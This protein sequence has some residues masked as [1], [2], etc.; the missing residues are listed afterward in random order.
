MQGKVVVQAL[1]DEKGNPV[2]FKVERSLNAFCDTEA[3][4]AIKSVKF[5]P[6]KTKGRPS[7]IWV[8]LPI[9]FRLRRP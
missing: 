5:N 7:K 1:I 8:V 2:E 9:E 3:I 4:K 6:A